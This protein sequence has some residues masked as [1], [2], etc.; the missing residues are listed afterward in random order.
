[1][2]IAVIG[3]NY[4]NCPIEIREKVS[5]VHSKKIE[6]LHLLKA[7][8]IQEVIIL[9]TCNRSEIYIKHDRL[10]EGI[11]KVKQFYS[12]FFRVVEVVSYLFVKRDIHAIRH[13]YE[14]AAGIDSII[15]GE[16]QI[17]G[18]VK[19]AQQDAI[20]EHTACKILNKVFREAISTAKQIKTSTK[21]SE[22][23][24]SI[25]HIAIKFLKQKLGDLEGK[26]GLIIGAGQMNQLAIKYLLEE[27]VGNLYVTNRTHKRMTS[28]TNY[29]KGLI[30][31]VYDERYKI[32]KEVDYVISATASPHIVLKEAYIPKV[33]HKVYM[34]DM[35]VPRDIEPAIGL[36]ENIEVYDIDDLEVIA[37]ANNIKREAQIEQAKQIIEDQL[38]ELMEWLDALSIDFIVSELTNKCDR[39]EKVTLEK[40]YKKIHILETEREDFERLLSKAFRK[41]MR[42]PIAKLKTTQDQDQ[43]MIYIEQIKSIFNLKEVE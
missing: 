13:L 24:L 6:A 15:I 20:T 18:Q 28:L 10:E 31:I 32:I 7:E 11:D 42:E 25:S 8:G 35:A 38:E 12:H 43:R 5:F 4:R 27:Q 1:M 30:P 23:A 14:V 33:D 26:K 39:I 40:F 19:E 21:I 3:V 34:M 36:V 29:Y 22:H 2:N 9:S 41:V 37:A 17:L 16:D